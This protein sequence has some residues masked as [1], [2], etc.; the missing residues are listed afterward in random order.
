MYENLLAVYLFIFKPSP[1]VTRGW[2]KLTLCKYTQ[3]CNLDMSCRGC[4]G[5]KRMRI[6]ALFYPC[7]TLPQYIGPQ[8]KFSKVPQ[9]HNWTDD[10]LSFSKKTIL[11]KTSAR[12]QIKHSIFLLEYKYFF[13][14]TKE[15]QY[16]LSKNI[17]K[18][19][20][21]P[22]IHELMIKDCSA[23]SL[24]KVPV[25]FILKRTFWQLLSFE[26]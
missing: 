2:S 18:T 19:A 23:C 24:F 11:E 7:L 4:A 20:A 25:P 8:I 14:C 1:E 26:Y 22:Q 10:P 16:D 15:L 9:P 6:Q 13:F 21:L 12:L 5:L 17:E 3:V